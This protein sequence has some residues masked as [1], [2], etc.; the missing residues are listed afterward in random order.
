MDWLYDELEPSE[1][2]RLDEHA[3]S[4]ARCRGQ[5]ES[6]SRL[7]A[8]FRDMP[9]EEPPAAV[10]TILL[11]EAGKRA[12]VR[13]RRSEEGQGLWAWLVEFVRPIAAHPA[14]AAVATLVV[15]VSVAGTIYVRGDRLGEEPTIQDPGRASERAPGN[16]P[17]APVEAAPEPSAA[18]STTTLARESEKGA[19]DRA[20][21][22]EGDDSLE[23]YP[24]SQD[25]PSVG[26]ADEKAQAEVSD[27]TEQR[28]EGRKDSTGTRTRA[29]ESKLEASGWEGQVQAQAYKKPAEEPL[30]KDEPGRFAR[31][32]NVV[33]SADPAPADEAEMAFDEDDALAAGGAGAG[34]RAGMES[35]A[36]QAPS[37]KPAKT[38]QVTGTYGG[39]MRGPGADM[40][41]AED[42]NK[43]VARKAPTSASVPATVPATATKEA[44]RPA[45]REATRTTDGAPGRKVAWGAAAPSGDASPAQDARRSATRKKSA[46]SRPSQAM[47]APPPPPMSAA[48]AEIGSAQAAQ[49]VSDKRD[50]TADV[51]WAEM[52]HKKLL[53]ALGAGSCQ[54]AARI[55]NDLM[56]RNPAYYNSR[57]SGSRELAS[58][59]KY[60]AAERSRRAKTRAQESQKAGKAA[61]K[62]RKAK[63]KAADQAVE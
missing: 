49:P 16:A 3:E 27:A 10:T 59:N 60:V 24:D 62:A 5:I 41:R 52:Q 55:A 17:A 56:E 9:E 23:Q 32:A 8:A 38:T 61:G 39:T 53:Q 36:R 37:P 29:G 42:A 21:A 51:T 12:P 20:Q 40:A 44:A 26:L 31:N 19:L 28:F 34:E 13:A 22:G 58:C 33:S 1:R 2:A 11:H 45:P 14:A 50:T 46:E 25:I 57:V 43:S 4:C 35:E 48:D 30:A 6:L 15:V 18:D 54:A 63:E 7:R 47:A